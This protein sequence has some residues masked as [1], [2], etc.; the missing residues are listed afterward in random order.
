ML[1]K[2]PL[3]P[4]ICNAA[5]HSLLVAEPW[6]DM[7]YLIQIHT[8]KRWF[9]G[10]LPTT[11]EDSLKR[12]DLALGASV[13]MYARNRRVTKVQAS[14]KGL[15]ERRF[16]K[17][18][19][20]HDILRERYCIP[21]RTTTLTCG[22]IEALLSSQGQE[23][24]DSHEM[25]LTKDQWLK[26]RKLTAAQL[27]LQQGLVNDE[28][29][30]QFDY[31]SMEARCAAY[32]KG[33]QETFLNDA[34]PINAAQAA[35][36]GETYQEFELFRPSKDPNPRDILEKHGMKDTHD[37]SLYIT[38]AV[39]M[40]DPVAAASESGFNKNA[41]LESLGLSYCGVSL[42][43]AAAAM[44]DVI[45]KDGNTEISKAR[46]LVPRAAAAYST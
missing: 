2:I 26:A 27:L 20:I 43:K 3:A 24:I 38:R 19:P 22:R 17:F 41:K 36:P 8:P 44:S 33:L 21:E 14:S 6:T 45:T 23:I 4:R 34:K 25:R 10:G 39:L 35:L 1:T 29:H 40:G 18:Y 30:M 9:I 16:R 7:D 31:L 28:L 5:R 46:A 42:K 13:T 32:I 11:V 12:F 37:L 15:G